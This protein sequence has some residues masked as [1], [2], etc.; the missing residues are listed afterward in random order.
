MS[1]EVCEDGL[2]LPWGDAVRSATDDPSV[3]PLLV[4]LML[5]LGWNFMGVAIISDVFMNAI[6][7]ITSKRA[8][9]W[10]PKT[11]RFETYT[12]WNATVA[13]LTLMALGSS[14]PEILLSVI[15]T[16]G[17]GFFSDDLGP[18]TIVGSAA[19]NLLMIIAICIVAIE[20]GETRKIEEFGVYVLTAIWSLFAYFWVLFAI[21]IN[22]PNVVEIWEGTMTL[23]F[24]PLL[25][26]SSYV[27]DRWGKSSEGEVQAK[28]SKVVPFDPSLLPGETVPSPSLTNGETNPEKTIIQFDMMKSAVLKTAGQVTV[29]VSRLG[30]TT[31]TMSVQYKTREGKAKEGTGFKPSEGCLTFAPGETKKSITVEIIEGK[32]CEEEED[33]CVDLSEPKAEAGEIELGNTTVTVGIITVG[34]KTGEQ[35]PVT[36]GFTQS[37]VTIVDQEADHEATFCVQRKGDCSGKISCKFETEEGTATEGLDFE[38]A[39]GTLVFEPGQQSAEISVNFM[40]RGRYSRSEILRLVLSEIEGGAEFDGEADGAPEV[41]ILTI[42]IQSGQVDNGLANGVR[43]RWE[44]AKVGHSNWLAQFSDAFKVDAGDDEDGESEGPSRVDLVLHIICV[45]WKLLFALCPPVDYCGGWVCFTCSLLWIGI[46]TAI[47]GDVANLM[48][49]AMCV[50]KSITAITFVA[51]GTSLPDTFA[52]RT[53]AQQDPTADASIVNVTG[54]NSVNVFLG[55]GLPW[56]MASL[57]WVG[58]KTE[59]WEEKFGFGAL[60]PPSFPI[61]DHFRRDGAFIVQAGELGFSVL[62]FSICAAVCLATLAWRRAVCGG[63]LGGPTKAKYATSA[64]LTF[65]WLAFVGVSSWNAMRIMTE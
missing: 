23:V 7:K 44:K 37:E 30:D 60:T 45:P 10:N 31:G 12:V 5:F 65:L 6:E 14:A 52:S 16:C 29:G 58:N 36:I 51:L 2:L 25:V 34:N 18:F 15:E 56:M 28:E 49:C 11:Q 46:C 17:A 13:N 20:D 40:G 1:C 22:T 57:Y 9:K 62:V 61:A 41:A 4:P 42:K 50:P 19:F 59:K 39:S 24:F 32:G 63:E 3:N 48:G 47:I 21:E 33:F 53:A 8:R 43:R 38:Q 27:V 26:G 35:L 55:L 54:S 64:L